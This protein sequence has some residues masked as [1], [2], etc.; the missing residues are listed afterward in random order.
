MATIDELLKSLQNPNKTNGKLQ[1]TRET[2]ER[3][4]NKD[5]FSELGLE[6]SELDSFLKD[7]VKDNPYNNIA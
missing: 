6:P 1:N 5:S 3:I 4:G 7:F 2:W